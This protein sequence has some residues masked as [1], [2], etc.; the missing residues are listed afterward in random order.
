MD[1]TLAPLIIAF[2]VACGGNV[3]DEHVDDGHAGRTVGGSTGTAG[4]TSGASGAAGGISGTAGGSAG[5]AGTA[6]ID[7]GAFGSCALPP[8]PGPCN[9]AMPRFYFDWASGFCREF[10]Y[11]GCGG[12]PN[13]FQ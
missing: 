13:N 10:T 6:S 7:A 12:N 2:V 9:A 1:R 4:S 11:G 8:D 3:S 5:S